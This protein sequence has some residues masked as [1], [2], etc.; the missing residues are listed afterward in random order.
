MPGTAGVAV[1]RS[2]KVYGA[3]SIGNHMAN[4]ARRLGWDVHVCDVDPEALRRMR[5]EIYPGRYGVWDEAIGLSS[6]EDAPRG[7]FDLIVVGTPP[8]VHVE[9]ALTAVT[10]A[11]E[12]IL[13][14]KPV[15]RPDLEGADALLKACRDA[16]VRGFVGYDHVVGASATS[17][18]EALRAGTAGDVQ[19]IDV[20][21]RE[22]WGGLLATH[23]WLAGPGDSYL[24][25]W[26]RGGGASGEHSHATNLW[27]HLAREAGAGEVVE[28]AA[29]LNYVEQD[30]GEYDDL[31]LMTLRT[32]QGLLGRVVQDVI[33]QPPA[34]RFRVQGTKGAI[35]WQGSAGEDVVRTTSEA[36]EH[37]LERHTKTRADDFV[38]ELRH[39]DRTLADGADS[40]I[41]LERG[42][43]TMLLV[44]AAHLSHRSRRAVRVDRS[45][46]YRPEA[47][48]VAE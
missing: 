9:V 34:K 17:V 48:H 11:P 2:V 31:C 18:S 3:G 40:P 14:E 47:L 12:A 6:V 19:T 32:D 7:G 10:E 27:Q 8:D 33:T 41:D 5:E 20:E 37:A 44:A 26:R 4:A 36:D 21:F 45:G 35:E 1:T 42:L 22:H 23:P 15:C 43:D 39:I 46:G 30:G 16:S 25:F 13:V 24:G 38:T 28:V 29:Q